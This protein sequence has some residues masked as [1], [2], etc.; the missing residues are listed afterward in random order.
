MTGIAPGHS[1]ACLVASPRIPAHQRHQYPE[2]PQEPLSIAM[3]LH[4]YE[5]PS[6]RTAGARKSTGDP[7]S[8]LRHFPS[9]ELGGSSAAPSS[10]DQL[11]VPA[12]RSAQV[13]NAEDLL[14]VSSSGGASCNGASNGGASGH[15]WDTFGCGI[16]ASGCI[17]SNLL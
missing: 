17:R 5:S 8:F 16:M 15:T 12:E 14:E 2:D 1:F 11:L 3:F 6:L 4:C 13:N 7:I 9:P 10:E